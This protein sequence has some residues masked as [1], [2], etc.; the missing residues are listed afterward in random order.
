M[1]VAHCKGAT[2]FARTWWENLSLYLR[3]I[4]WGKR[5]RTQRSV[6]RKS[7]RPKVLFFTNG[8]IFSSPNSKQTALSLSLSPAII[9]RSPSLNTR[10]LLTASCRTTRGQCHRLPRTRRTFVALSFTLSHSGYFSPS[11][12][13]RQLHAASVAGCRTTR[14]Q[15]RWLP[16]NLSTLATLA[17]HSLL[18][19]HTRY[20]RCTLDL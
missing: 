10:Q 4:I 11:L 6:R 7:H 20:S 8:I 12:N 1:C 2:H 18:S 5:C 9:T 16:H 14:S 19:L 13:T 15:C 3:R 17:A